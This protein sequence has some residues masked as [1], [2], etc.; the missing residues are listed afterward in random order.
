MLDAGHARRQQAWVERGGEREATA[1]PDG[2]D[3][4]SV[5]GLRHEAVQTL[6][7][8]RPATLGQALRLAGVTP[9]DVALLEVT[10]ARHARAESAPAGPPGA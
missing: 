10:L 9:A 1:V 5:R 3:Y 8:A 4:G 6:S 7:A 2:F